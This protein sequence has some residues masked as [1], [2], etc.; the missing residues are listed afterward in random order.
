MYEG[1][2]GEKNQS[3]IL[4]VERTLFPTPV[5]PSLCFSLSVFHLL[6]P[7][8]IVQTP[9]L[10]NPISETHLPPHFSKDPILAFLR[11]ESITARPRKDV[12]G[13]ARREGHQLGETGE[14][15]TTHNH[16]FF[17]TSINHHL[18]YQIVDVLGS[19]EPFGSFTIALFT[20]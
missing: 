3:Q 9:L 18:P 20:T 5:P 6:S 10:R 7:L 16:T 8:R 15:N 19:P 13:G 4:A 17:Q 14:L 1:V 11:S 2:F 12:H